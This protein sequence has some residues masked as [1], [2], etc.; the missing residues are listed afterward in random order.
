M[1]GVR[2]RNDRK[3]RL[4]REWKAGLWLDKKVGRI[5]RRLLFA[6]LSLFLVSRIPPLPF[7]RCLGSAAGIFIF[8]FLLAR[9]WLVEAA[10]H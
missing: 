7:N 9:R 3:E 1:S 4:I 8:F 5:V 10:V 6:L 2:L